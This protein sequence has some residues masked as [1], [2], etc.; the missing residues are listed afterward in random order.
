MKELNYLQIFL[1]NA[2]EGFNNIFIETLDFFHKSEFGLQSYSYEKIV[3]ESKL[4]NCK[5]KEK[6]DR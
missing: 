4:K 5:Q 1:L 3:I 2:L 6:S